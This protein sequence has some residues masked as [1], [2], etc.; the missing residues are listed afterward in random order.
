[1]IPEER[2]ERLTLRWVGNLAGSHVASWRI[3]GRIRQKRVEA[4][5]C[6]DAA[7]TSKRVGIRVSVPAGDPLADD[8]S[9]G[10]M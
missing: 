8:P 2:Q 9:Q 10:E 5:L 7:K 4:F 3:R 6:P 1:M